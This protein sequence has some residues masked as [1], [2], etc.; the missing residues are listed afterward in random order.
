MPEIKTKT[1][2][3][4]EMVD[5]ADVPIAQSAEHWNEY[6]LEDGVTVRVKFAVGSIMRIPGKY[7]PENNPLYIVK[8]TVVSIPVVPENLR[9]KD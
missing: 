8:G 6:K 2:V 3:N 4:N 1:M 7:D 9:K 5:A